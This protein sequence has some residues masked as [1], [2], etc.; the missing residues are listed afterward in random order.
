LLPNG[1]AYQFHAEAPAVVLIQ[2]IEGAVT[3]QRWAEICQTR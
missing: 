2:T 3:V 1:A